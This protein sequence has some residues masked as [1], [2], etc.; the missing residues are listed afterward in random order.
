MVKR[1]HGIDWHKKYS[2]IS[3]LNRKGEEVKFLSKCY[4]L[5]GYIDGLGPEDA[6]IVEASTASFYWADRIEANG[7]ICH[8][9][10]PRK[11]KIIR[12]SWN[13]TDKQDSRNMAKA[14]WV[15]IVTEEFGIPTVY[16]PDRVVRELRKLFS[17]Y[18][19]LNRQ[20]SMLK[21]TIHA[22][23]VENGVDLEST[24]YLLSRRYGEER[25]KE[26]ELSI[27]SEVII[28]SSL[29][30]LWKLGEEKE[31]MSQEIIL[32]GEPL[33]EAVKLLIT[34]RGITPLI[35]LAFLTDVGNI[36]RFRSVR[37]M[38][39]YL[40]LVPKIKESGGK[41]RSG[42]IN[43]E[44]RKLTH[45]LL[46]QSIPHVIESSIYFRKYYGDLVSRRGV[47]RARVA[48]IRKLCGMMRRMLLSGECY[49]WIDESLFERKLKKYENEL[50]KLQGNK[51]VA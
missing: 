50:E 26:L 28:E 39:A 33:K 46:T 3:V 5:R 44:S 19:Q 27:A 24:R 13:K 49:R 10:D 7:A 30:L 29:K 43:R 35:A 11:F 8:I 48:V 25:L 9:I 31:R 42:H 37:K 21:N 51:K 2:T 34:I 45:T 47:G 23:C 4:D 16:K 38:N 17:Y 41:E 6:V 32:V 40:G 18:Q 20:I 22:I 15:Y 1:F 14:L 36:E 12:E